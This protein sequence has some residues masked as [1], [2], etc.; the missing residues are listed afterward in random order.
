MQLE[1]AKARIAALEEDL[2]FKEFSLKEARAFKEDA[3]KK[4]EYYETKC[5]TL[6]EIFISCIKQI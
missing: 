1:E 6:K 2:R 5:K 4:G 3:E